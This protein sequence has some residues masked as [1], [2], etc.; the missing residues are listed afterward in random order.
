MTIDPGVLVPVPPLSA[1][2]RSQALAGAVAARRQRA[3]VKRELKQGER[4]L[5]SV[6]SDGDRVPAI[7]QLK[8]VDLIE[9]M[10][11]IGPATATRI[12]DDLGIARS[13]R[14]RGLGV[15]QVRSL[16]QRFETA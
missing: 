5:R 6:V 7:A 1:Q 12:M 13:R 8:V 16:L 14:V 3:A 11:G 2:Q 9:S 4:T 15:Q 10:P